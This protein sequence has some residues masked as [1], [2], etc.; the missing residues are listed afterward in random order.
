MARPRA[1]V[2]S[3]K[4]RE[5]ASLGAPITEVAKTLG[6]SADTI[7]RRFAGDY[8]KGRAELR[9]TLR[10]AQLREAKRGNTALLI[11]LGKQYLGQSDRSIDEYLLEAIKIAGL[12][13]EDL[14]GLIANKDK[15]QA[16][17]PIKTFEQ[18]VETAGYPTPYP[19]QLEMRSFAIDGE[20]ARLLLGSRGY[21]KT[22][23]ITILGVAYDIYLHRET[24]WLVITKSKARNSALIEEIAKALM[25]NG[26]TLEKQ[27]STC[28]R[29]NGLAGKD[30]SVEALTV[31][32]SIRGRHPKK[33][34]MDDPVTDEDTSEAVRLQVQRKY[35]ELFKLCSNLLIL[36]QP[37]HSADLY[38]KL[39]PLLTKMEVPFGS[40]PELD[41]DLEA[42]RL[43]GVDE[44]SIQAS[45]FLKIV[46]DGSAPFEKINYIDSMP[47]GETVAFL[48][49]SHKGKDA[50]ALTIMKSHFQGVAV[51][52]F[53]AH[54]AWNHWLDEIVPKLIKYRV[55]KICIE[56]NGLGDQPVILLRGLL[57]DKG[58]GVVGIDSTDNKHA[59]IMAAGAFAH[60]IHLSKESD[61][62]YTDQVIQYEYG[63]VTDDA[64]D[65]L[66]TCLKWLGLIRGKQ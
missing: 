41:H 31:K 35:N 36:G 48:D 9:E 14:L 15:L 10:M 58:I 2:D 38:A 25:K 17:A 40:I 46:S 19:K 34:L 55:K 45:Y 32:S 22:D 57:K 20:G 16:E 13:K 49:P 33:S 8:A 30:H 59:R 53:A 51:V 42:Q 27:N 1:D 56:C 66:A 6:V 64:P 24:S 26:V 29:V 44:K 3:D 21:G 47:G 61:R 52:G 65:S 37:A 7:E 28:I 54:R 63:A 5:L 50:S 23:Y 4:V 39:R 18:F 62:L 43:A 60:L 12:S 11:F